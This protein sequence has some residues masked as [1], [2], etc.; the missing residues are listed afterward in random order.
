[1][2]KQRILVAALGL[3]LL[4]GLVF[5]PVLAFAGVVLVALLVAAW[6]FHHL[7][8]LD[9]RLPSW[10]TILGVALPLLGWVVALRPNTAVVAGLMVSLLGLSTL[11]LVRYERGHDRAGTGLAYGVLAAV[12]LG[13]LGGFLIGL[14]AQAGPWGWLWAL[15]VV[16]VNDSSAYFVGRRWGHHAMSP[17]LSPK[18]TWEGFWGGVA[19]AVLYGLTFPWVGE[20]LGGGPFPT[21]WVAR[22]GLVL[23]LALLTPLG[24]LT[25]SLL[26][27]QAGVKDSGHWLPGHGG[28]LDRVDAWL[29][30][31]VLAY[32]WLG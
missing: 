32:A 14:R 18:K 23:S 13:V 17:R 10:S 20:A 30:A 1:M 8:P 27:R 6:E 9:A 5:S 7:I 21:S 2:L 11:A 29:W 15:S 12:Y 4:I 28:I 31:G 26:K 19:V 24:D 22:L 16:W 3:P 25:E